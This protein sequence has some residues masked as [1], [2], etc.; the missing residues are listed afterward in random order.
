MDLEFTNGGDLVNSKI[1]MC[2]LFLP[3]SAA[4]LAIMEL[5]PSLAES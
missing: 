3:I 5:L 2:E 4:F 1:L